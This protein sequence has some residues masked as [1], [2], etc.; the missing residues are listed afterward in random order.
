M[1]KMDQD[2][3]SKDEDINQLNV[4]VETLLQDSMKVKQLT[5]TN[6]DLDEQ[7]ERLKIKVKIAS[8][9]SSEHVIFLYVIIQIRDF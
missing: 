3:I 1:A 5:K 8:S 9:S 4:Q 6:E 2:L 7:C